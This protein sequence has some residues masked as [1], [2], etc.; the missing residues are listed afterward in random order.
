MTKYVFWLLFWLSV[1]WSFVFASWF[2]YTNLSFFDWTTTGKTLE[3]NITVDQ[4]Q[5]GFWVDVSNPTTESQ[6]LKLDFVSQMQTADGRTSCDMIS[7][8]EFWENL[9]WNMWTFFVDSL[10]TERRSVDF[11]FPVCTSWTFD[12]CALQLAPTETNIWSFDVV[13]GKANFFT[14]HV[15]PSLLCTPFN[16]KVFPGSRPWANFANQ[17]EIRFYNLAK[18]LVYS[19]SLESDEQGI[20][21]LG[22]TLPSWIYYVVYKWQSQLASYL[23]GVN[24]I[25]WEEFVLDFTTGANLFNTQNK[26]ISQNDGFQYQIAGDLKNIQWMYDF[27]INGNDIAILTI[28]WFID[29]GITVL[30]PK[31]LN[32]DSAINVSDISIVGINFEQTD[33]YLW[34]TV[35]TW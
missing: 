13:E 24:I 8:K 7:G 27:M 29:F 1:L 30:D 10:S 12:A 15:S 20:S 6:S 25:E 17:G 26:S 18:D 35:F 11:N 21:V 33:P 34:S 2:W 9:I 19:G 23:S 31:N 4:W 16:L 5:T 14:L 3:M 22:D 28:S 32:G